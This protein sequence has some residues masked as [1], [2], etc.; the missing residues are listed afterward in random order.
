MVAG[1]RPEAQRRGLASLLMQQGLDAADR[2]ACLSNSRRP[3]RHAYH[4]RFG[5][6]VIDHALELVPGGPAHVA[7]RCPARG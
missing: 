1:V 4:E 3:I 6:S 5:F 2:I 7:M